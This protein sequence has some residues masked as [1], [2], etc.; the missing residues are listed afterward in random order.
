M[1]CQPAGCATF[2]PVAPSL[3]DGF[4]SDPG[5]DSCTAVIV[6]AQ[7]MHHTGHLHAVGHARLH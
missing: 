1:R 3:E 2:V 6:G 7:G 4:D 5:Y